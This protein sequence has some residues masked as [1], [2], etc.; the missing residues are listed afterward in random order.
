VLAKIDGMAVARGVMDETESSVTEVPSRGGGGEK[1][2]CR[3]KAASASAKA[4]ARLR[5]SRA[6]SETAQ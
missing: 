2:S 1:T 3:K 5:W 6:S 4:N